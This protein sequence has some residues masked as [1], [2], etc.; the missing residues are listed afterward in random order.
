MPGTF[1]IIYLALASLALLQAGLFTFQAFEN[2]RFTRARCR[3]RDPSQPRGRVL[4]VAP[5]KGS[6]TGSAK[7]SNTCC[8]RTTPIMRS[9][10]LSNRL[11]IPRSPSSTRSFAYAP[12]FQRHCAS[13]ARP[14]IAARRS[15]TCSL[16]RPNYRQTRSTWRSS[17]P[18]PG[19]APT[20]CAA[21][22]RLDGRDSGAATGYRWFVPARPSLANL[23]LSSINANVALLLGPGDHHFVWGGSWAISRTVFE[24]IGL[25]EAWQGTLSDDLVATQVLR[26]NQLGIE[27]EP[28][29]LVSSP[30]D[31]GFPQLFEFLAGNT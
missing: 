5:C 22:S 29:C 31:V 13:R 10:S 24:K 28:R 11:T 16:P 7:I 15:T 8:F 17:I 1:W 26:R 20:G 25:R 19:L 30:L 27:Y 3:R 12:T 23:L 18:T 9:G 2:R 14:P 6:E 4:L 21:I